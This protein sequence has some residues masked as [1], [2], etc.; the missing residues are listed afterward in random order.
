[1]EKDI[2]EIK[3]TLEYHGRLLE[4]ILENFDAGRKTREQAMPN[5][6]AAIDMIGEHPA[7]KANPSMAGLIKNML[8]GIAGGAHGN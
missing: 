1:M 3:K 7:I 5:I 6:K 4:T 2:A 8:S